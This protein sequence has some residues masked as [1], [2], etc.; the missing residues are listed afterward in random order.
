[1]S[2]DD[3]REA[4]LPS[5]SGLAIVI[6]VRGHAAIEQLD[7][8]TDDAVGLQRQLTAGAVHL[9]CPHTML[10]VR[11][12]QG[13]LLLFRAAAKPMEPTLGGLEGPVALR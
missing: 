3:E 6:V 13:P 9:V 11:A 1:M 10:R 12:Q 7:D 5:S 2:G 4:V 8:A